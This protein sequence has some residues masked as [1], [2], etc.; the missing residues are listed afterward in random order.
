MDKIYVPKSSCKKVEFSNGGHLFRFSFHA[1]TFQ[2]FLAQQLQ[3]GEFV[4]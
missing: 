4:N 3:D 2:K 1:E